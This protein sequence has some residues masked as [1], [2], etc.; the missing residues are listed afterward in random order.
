MSSV[1]ALHSDESMEKLKSGKIYFPY[2]PQLLTRG[3]SA[4]Q[5]DQSVFPPLRL[6]YHW[7]AYKSIRI[8]ELRENKVVFLSNN[9][10]FLS[11]L[12]KETDFTQVSSSH[13]FRKIKICFKPKW[14]TMIDLN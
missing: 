3:G 11:F 2:V 1:R 4:R 10:C 8:S 6:S 9:H 14:R 12:L 5:D 13:V 7:G